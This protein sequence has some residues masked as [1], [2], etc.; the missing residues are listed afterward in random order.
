MAVMTKLQQTYIKDI[1]S[2][3]QVIFNGNN[4]RNNADLFIKKYA[5]ENREFRVKNNKQTRP[6]GKQLRFIKDIEEVLEIKYTGRTV[7]S[8]SK[9]IQKYLTEFDSRTG[10]ERKIKQYYNGMADKIDRAQK[11]KRARRV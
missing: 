4:T 2:N 5:E 7:K 11:N 6:T 10:I 9:F 3:L 1:E 8:A